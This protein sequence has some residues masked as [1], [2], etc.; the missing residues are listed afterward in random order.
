[1]SNSKR[2]HH[3]IH[4]SLIGLGAVSKVTVLHKVA[5]MA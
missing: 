1:M 3:A 5:S 4:K 2:R